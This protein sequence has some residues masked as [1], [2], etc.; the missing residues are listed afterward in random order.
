MRACAILLLAGCNQLLG[1][2]KTEHAPPDAPPGCP[3]IGTAP[4]F[5]RCVHQVVSSACSYYTLG[6]DVGIALAVC[7]ASEIAGS[8]YMSGP[9]DGELSPIAILPS[10]A[11]TT[12]AL[13]KLAPEGDELVLQ[14]TV[15]YTKPTFSTYR[16][17]P[18]D[19][20]WS[21]AAD[22]PIP[23]AGAHSTLSR[24]PSRHL[25]VSQTGG[26]DMR[27]YVRDSA[28]GWSEV[29]PPYAI[30]ELGATPTTLDL[31]P[32]GLRLVFTATTRDVWYADRPAITARFS[33]GSMVAGV[34]RVSDPFLTEDCNRLYFSGL[35]HIL[36]EPER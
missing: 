30:G 7:P 6:P 2:D 20:T 34:P 5:S 25:L 29:L 12:T 23:G 27:E 32:D 22:L 26:A 17:N 24:G 8:T 4:V 3:P 14:Q 16:R 18:A 36:Y 15:S 19:G 28:G 35:D 1:L 33:R 10:G 21:W 9:I 11:N 13:P 31:S